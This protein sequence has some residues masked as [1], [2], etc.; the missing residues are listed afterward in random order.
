MNPVSSAL[1][2]GSKFQ[3]VY[4]YLCKWWYSIYIYITGGTTHYQV[5]PPSIA[6]V[7]FPAQVYHGMW[8]VH[9]GSDCLGVS[10][11]HGGFLS[12]ALYP[13]S[14]MASNGLYWKI[15]FFWEMR[16]LETLDG[17]NY[18]KHN[19]RPFL[20]YRKPCFQTDHDRIL[21]DWSTFHHEMKIVIGETPGSS[22]IC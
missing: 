10:E 4:I 2:V 12:H 3:R 5:G 19:H 7:F 17:N 9:L 15:P 1:G 14:W 8:H 11:N 22:G 18:R 13:N 21:P 6:T 20:S 16:F